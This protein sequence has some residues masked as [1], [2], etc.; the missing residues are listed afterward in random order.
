MYLKEKQAYYNHYIQTR[1]DTSY[2]QSYNK[3]RTVVVTCS[4]VP[5]EARSLL[6]V[7]SNL[8]G[9][10]KNLK[11]RF[12]LLDRRWFPLLLYALLRGFP[13]PWCTENG[14][15]TTN[16]LKVGPTQPR[17]VS[18]SGKSRFP[19]PSTTSLSNNNLRYSNLLKT[20]TL[21]TP[22]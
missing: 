4:I 11:R 1:L 6:K 21:A 9:F 12:S 18:A 14:Y 8:Y 3:K 19:L 16:W 20:I 7:P 22:L 2:R 10:F 5:S 13:T 17:K 15:R